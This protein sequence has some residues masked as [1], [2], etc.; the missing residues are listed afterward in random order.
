MPL[1][2][3][4]GQAADHIGTVLVAEGTAEIQTRGTSA[5]ETVRFRDPVFLNDTVRTGAGSKVKVILRDDSILTLAEHSEIHLT[6]F[7]LAP[8][9]R[10]VIV[11]LALG[12]LRVIAE[13]HF[14]SGS[15]TEVHTPNAVVGVEGTTFI[16]RF[17]P[18]DTTDV[19]S[20]EGVVTVRNRALLALE[21]QPILQNF[22]TRVVGT[23]PPTRAVEV[24][25]NTLQQLAQEVRVIEQSPQEVL[26]SEKLQA[27]ETPRE[28][29]RASTGD[30]RVPEPSPIVVPPPVPPA[31]VVVRDQPAPEPG[32]T[33]QTQIVT[34]DTAIAVSPRVRV[35]LVFPGR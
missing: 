25:T 28:S 18:P 4:W 26:T 16:V 15:V 2:F 8:Q 11:T 12:T 3:V 23:A 9:Q 14:G 30:T 34:P 35:R 22:R 33:V 7:L 13:R 31:P 6:D 5:W 1:R 10:R 29:T 32:S 20:L 19:T 27:L 21:F 24:S 17:I